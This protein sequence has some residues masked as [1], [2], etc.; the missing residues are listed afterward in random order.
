MDDTVRLLSALWSGPVGVALLGDIIYVHGP[1][2]KFPSLLVVVVVVGVE[3]KE[4][5][6]SR[7]KGKILLL[8]I[9]EIES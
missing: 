9:Q 7:F 4:C 1:I 3:W 8:P 5:L 6:C 2:Q